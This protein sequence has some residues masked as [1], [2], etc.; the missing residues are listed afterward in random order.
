MKYCPYCGE[1]LREPEAQFCQEC[2]KQFVG[3]RTPIEFPDTGS[4]KSKKNIR[5]TAKKKRWFRAAKGE[6]E[7]A[8]PE[9]PDP[10]LPEDDGYDGYYDDVLPADHDARQ[11]GLDR[12]LIQRIALLAAAAILVI[13]ACVAMMYFL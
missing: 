13:A 3:E 6:V 12:G 9:M 5:G 4:E 10:E 1:G 8:S 7:A 11:D 2:G